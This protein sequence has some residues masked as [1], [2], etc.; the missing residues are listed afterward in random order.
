MLF[1]RNVNGGLSIIQRRH[2]KIGDTFI[3]NNSAKVCKSIIGLDANSLHG[4]ALR[5]YFSTGSFLRRF[6]ENLFKIEPQRDKYFD[7]F[8]CFEYIAQ[9]ETVEI[10]Y[11]LSHNKEFIVGPCYVDAYIP[12]K[13]RI[14]EFCGC[15]YHFCKGVDY[16]KFNSDLKK[17]MLKRRDHLN[18]KI[19]FL[20]HL[21]FEV[22]VMWE[23]SYKKLLILNKGLR[24]FARNKMPIFSKKYPNKVSEEQIL[25]C[26][27]TGEFVG[28]AECDIEIPN[29][30]PESLETDMPS[31][32]YF[33]DY[34]PL[35]A[36]TKVTFEQMSPVMKEY[37]IKQGLSMGPRKAL[38]SGLRAKRVLFC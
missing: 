5:G 15:F 11:K 21:N 12:S 16:K 31:E 6:V 19:W 38:L 29:K 36:R 33:D 24:E 23:C 13:R 35:F 34:P 26:V 25:H 9:T 2:E 3:R 32:E 10:Q 1:Q 20:S 8:I 4:Y 18:D 30:L 27:R 14:I 22:N 7:M 17:I 37:I 28:F